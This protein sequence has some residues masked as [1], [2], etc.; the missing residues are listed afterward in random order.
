MSDEEPVVDQVPV[1]VI[2]LQCVNSSAS[3]PTIFEALDLER[4]I[5][6]MVPL[7]NLITEPIQKVMISA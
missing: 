3:L 5:E 1:L 7:G 4:R 6:H 2:R